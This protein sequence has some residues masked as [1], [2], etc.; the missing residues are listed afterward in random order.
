MLLFSSLTLLKVTIRHHAVNE[1]AL[2]K[3]QKHPIMFD[4]M[5]H[6]SYDQITTTANNNISSKHEHVQQIHLKEMTTLGLWWR[7]PS[8]LYSNHHQDEENKKRT[9]KQ[10]YSEPFQNALKRDSSKMNECEQIYQYK[11]FKCGQSVSRRRRMQSDG[12]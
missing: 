2:K 9:C 1:D 10:K 5:N 4:P 12:T 11:R 3:T 6:D 7:N 8:K